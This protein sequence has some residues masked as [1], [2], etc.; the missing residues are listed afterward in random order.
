MR[1]ISEYQNADIQLYFN[2]T[3]GPPEVKK[4]QFEATFAATRFCD[5]L[6]FVS[7]PAS[8]SVIQDTRLGSNV[9]MTRTAGHGR[10][11]MEFFSDWLQR[12]GVRHIISMQVYDFNPCHSDKS[13]GSVL[14]SFK[15]EDLDW[16]KIDLD[17]RTIQEACNEVQRLTLW[18][19]GNNTALRAWSEPNGLPA[20]PHLKEIRI[21]LPREIQVRC[22]ITP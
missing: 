20:L 7:F 10:R 11:D 2:Y 18:W 22:S 12:K 16:R 9:S 6:K 14:R 5:I 1:S 21:C 13:I 17:P 15:I 8:V 3:G 19:S 4:G